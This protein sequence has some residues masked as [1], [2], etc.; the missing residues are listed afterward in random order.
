LQPCFAAAFIEL[1]SSQRG[2]VFLARGVL[3]PYFVFEIFMDGFVRG[4]S[5]T[6]LKAETMTVVQFGRALG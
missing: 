4:L 3:G 6:G 1:S 2:R 5:L